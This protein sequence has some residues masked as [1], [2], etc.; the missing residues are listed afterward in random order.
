MSSLLKGRI[1]R[2][3][4][5]AAIKERAQDLEDFLADVRSL[6]IKRLIALNRGSVG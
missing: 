3:E 2:F 4:A 5:D 6:E 1:E